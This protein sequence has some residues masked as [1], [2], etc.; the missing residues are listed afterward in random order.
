[1][2]PRGTSRLTPCSLIACC[3]R[4]R[5]RGLDP[6]QIT[7]PVY[8]LNSVRHKSEWLVYPWTEWKKLTGYLKVPYGEG[9]GLGAAFAAFVPLGIVFFS[10]T[11][12]ANRLNRSR[13]LTLLLTLWRSRGG[14]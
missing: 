2:R 13:N 10:V 7:E 11:A 5:D 9:D 12:I 8:E 6:S 1:V 3:V 14:F 4:T